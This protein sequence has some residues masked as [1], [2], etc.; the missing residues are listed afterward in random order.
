MKLIKEK[1]YDY[2]RFT[3]QGDPIKDLGIGLEPTIR[4]WMSKLN[5]SSYKLTKK[6]SINVYHN[7][8]LSEKN[9]SEFPPYI[10]FNHITGGFHCDN[11][12]LTSLR[13]CPYSLSG[14]FMCSFNK[15]VNL[16]NGPTVVKQSYGASYD[17]LESLE[18]IGEIIG[19]SIYI[20]D[21]NLKTLEYIPPIIKKDL[22]IYNNPI[23][24]LEYFPK[25]VSGD[26]YF[27]PSKILTKISISKICKVGGNIINFDL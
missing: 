5:I 2:L 25:E 22:F 7:V 12:K 6:F 26:I 17:E 23:E 4:M 15:L 14:S 20:N 11:N 19:E 27:T 18:G 3:E 16:K 1:L 10:K 24:T 21:N 9:I 13:G 8:L